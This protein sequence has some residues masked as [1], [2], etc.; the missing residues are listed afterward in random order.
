M[1]ASRAHSPRRLA[2][3]ATGLSG[4]PDEAP[5]VVDRTNVGRSTGVDRPDRDPGDRAAEPDARRDLFDLECEARLVASERRLGK[6]ARDEPVAGLVVRDGAT[7]C[8]RE[9]DPA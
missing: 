8:S 6:A 4:D 7:D 5:Q 2:D 9:S 1:A 3:V